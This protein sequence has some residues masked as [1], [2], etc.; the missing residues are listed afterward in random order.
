MGNVEMTCCSTVEKERDCEGA[1][2]VDV[3]EAEGPRPLNT[4]SSFRRSE[5]FA[6]TVCLENHLVP[7]PNAPRVLV[8]TSPVYHADSFPQLPVGKK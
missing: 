2:P 3:D 8:R 6:T 5:S 1:V 4:Q 7:S